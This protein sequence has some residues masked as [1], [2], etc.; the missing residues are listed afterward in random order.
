MDALLNGLI[1]IGG[2]MYIIGE[3]IAN[4]FLGAQL[5][6]T[7]YDELIDCVAHDILTKNGACVPGAQLAVI[8]YEELNDLLIAN[9]Q[10][11]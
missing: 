10:L 9:E 7:E 11:C 6:V 4:E 5:A 1:I 8:E 3:E 2:L